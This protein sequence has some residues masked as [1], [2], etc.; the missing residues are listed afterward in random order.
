MA[1]PFDTIEL[2]AGTWDVAV[3]GG[4][5]AIR[6]GAAAVAQDMSTAVRL[7]LGE[8]VYDALAGVPYLSIFGQTT[9]LPILKSDISTAAA[10]IPGAEN[11]VCYI[12][13][14]KD[15]C[16]SGQVQAEVDGVTVVA[17]ISG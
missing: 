5:F 4:S 3:V 7:F 16:V 12:E 10:A 1:A 6:K 14:V 17:S 8:Y 13:S 11:V 2:D 9:S 15:R